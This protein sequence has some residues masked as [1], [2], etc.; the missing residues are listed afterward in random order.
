V[1]VLYCPTRNQLNTQKLYRTRKTELKRG[2]RLTHQEAQERLSNCSNP[3]DLFPQNCKTLVVRRSWSLKQEESSSSHLLLLLMLPPQRTLRHLQV[4]SS[5]WEKRLVKELQFEPLRFLLRRRSWLFL[6]LCKRLHRTLLDYEDLL[7]LNRKDR[8]QRGERRRF[9]NR[10]IELK[11][12]EKEE[13]AR[14]G[15]DR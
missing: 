15:R 12:G 5:K 7:E 8:R 13:L 14:K 9:C 1:S 11:S 2:K 4:V 10:S 6:L 3:F